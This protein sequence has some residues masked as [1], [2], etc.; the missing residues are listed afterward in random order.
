ME[1]LDRLIKFNR[2]FSKSFKR[3]IQNMNYRDYLELTETGHTLSLVSN[4]NLFIT[5]SE[6]QLYKL[7]RN[8]IISTLKNINYKRGDTWDRTSTVGFMD[9]VIKC[10]FDL[11]DVLSQDEY[12]SLIS[13]RYNIPKNKIYA[14]M[15]LILTNLKRN[16]DPYGVRKYFSDYELLMYKYKDNEEKLYNDI[17]ENKLSDK[18]LSLVK[19]IFNV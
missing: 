18:E 15:A 9:E 1:T 8:V 11:D 4:G 10:K 14:N 3:Y 19:K 7:R 16:I 2:D 12:L 6:N 13:E 17:E 5:Y